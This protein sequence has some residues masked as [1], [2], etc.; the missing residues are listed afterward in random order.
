MP[1]DVEIYAE[2]DR[3]LQ[4]AVGLDER[5]MTA[6]VY[7]PDYGG[8]GAGS[9][10]Q[11]MVWRPGAG[12]RSASGAMQL[13]AA[14]ACLRLLSEAVATLPI[15]T[16]TRS[17]G[18]RRPYRPRPA[19]LDFT[20][21]GLARTGYL[22][23]VMLSL[24]TDG[25]A[26][27]ATPRDEMGVPASLIPLDPA[28]VSVRRSAGQVTYEVAGRSYGAWDL[29]HIT[30]MTLPG[31]LTGVSPITAA[32]SVLEGAMS[33]QEFGAA[34]LSNAAVPPAYI[35]VP[36]TPGASDAA[37]NERAR[38]IGA[39]WNA[40][41]GG[42]AN[43]G[44][45][46]VL[47]G[48]AELHTVA[49]SPQDAQWLESRQFGVQEIARIYGVPPHLI[50]DSSNSTSWGSGLAEQN[51]AFGQFSLRPWLERIEEAHG[52]LLTTHGLRDVF[53]RLNLDALLRA[54]TRDRY[55]AHAVG[56]ASRFLLPN[57]ARAYEDLPP[58]PGGD[59]FPADHPGGDA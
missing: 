25:N 52:R 48:D 11:G 20:P 12:V 2:G 44:K 53:L 9:W 51:L 24:L 10:G 28:R 14:Y 54:S 26:Y 19:Y 15:D 36:R 37:E 6:D 27:V 22:S 16:F 31:E 41:N 40:T 42:T 13:S 5:S 49:V 58:L 8:F 43:A 21:P 39:V 59:Q 17:D 7:G 1:T 56:I 55:D 18:T 29:M 30:G 46:G 33:A 4:A 47:T 35:R 34:F 50:A 23:Q 57:E 38:Q 32:R 3:R 45:V